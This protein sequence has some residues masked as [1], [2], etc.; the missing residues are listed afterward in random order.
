MLHQLSSNDILIEIAEL[1]VTMKPRKSDSFVC[2]SAFTWLRHSFTRYHVVIF[3]LLF[4]QL[5]VL[6]YDRIT[7]IDCL[8][9]EM[10][11]T[12]RMKN[13]KLVKADNRG[14]VY[15]FWFN[16]SVSVLMAA[17]SHFGEYQPEWSKFYLIIVYVRNILL[18][19]TYLAYEIAIS[20]IN[21][22]NI[23]YIVAN[24]K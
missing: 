3:V 18:N 14:R 23:L 10:R 15:F 1:S 13:L 11:F 12:T 20:H 8:Q 17:V 24:H 21:K 9:F 22:K 7:I 19:H 2:T 4:T 16:P 6:F 5:S